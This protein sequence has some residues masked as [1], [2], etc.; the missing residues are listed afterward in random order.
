MIYR[1]ISCNAL[2]W[3][4][5]APARFFGGKKWESLLRKL[6]KSITKTN[7]YTSEKKRSLLHCIVWKILAFFA[8]IKFHLNFHESILKKNIFFAYRSASFCLPKLLLTSELNVRELEICTHWYS[9][10]RVAWVLVLTIEYIIIHLFRVTGYFD[11]PNFSLCN[12]THQIQH[13]D[14]I[15]A[16]A[17]QRY[18]KALNRINNI[19]LPPVG[20]H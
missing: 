1:R 14:E 2:C 7:P 12:L 13:L 8:V 10:T 17:V 6:W 16:W 15:N 20:N 5:C 18:P 11:H 4:L 3:I 19:F 9:S